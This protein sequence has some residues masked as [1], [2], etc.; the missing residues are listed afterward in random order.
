MVFKN[1]SFNKFW[2]FSCSFQLGIPIIVLLAV[3]AG[4]GTIIES[5]F[6]DALAAKKMV[7]DS[8]MMWVTM[9]LL[10]YNLVVVVV[11]RWPWKRMHYP[12]VVVHAGLI[13]I[14]FGGFITGKY[15]LDGQV[16]VP[17]SGQNN[18]ISVP[19]TDLVVYA[20][21][22]GD[23]YSKVVDREVDFFMH[24]PSGDMPYVL[25]LGEDKIQIIDFARYAIL[26]NKVKANQDLQSGASI[27]FQLMNAN[28]KQVQQIT[29]PK[30]NREVVFNLGPAKVILG[31]PKKGTEP[32]NEIYIVPVDADHA[33]YFIF[34]RDQ[35]KV[36]K[37]GQIK[38]GD[39]INTGWMGLEFRLLDYIQHAVEEYDITKVET[40][41][42]LTVQAVKIQHRDVIRWMALNDLVK[43]FGESKAYLFSYQN[44]RIDLGFQIHLDQFD[45]IRYE[46]TNKAKEYASKVSIVKNGEK[47]EARAKPEDLTLISMNEPMKHNG[48]TIYQA[49]FQEDEMTGK[50][51][52]S[53]FSVN[54]DPGRPIKYMGSLILSVGIIWLFYQRR[55]KATAV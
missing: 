5:Q 23:R 41:T 42:P 22:D 54:K 8:W 16:S 33:K 19:S 25:D 15:G 38:I 44:R 35:K 28:V 27:R 17:I 55:K 45:V 20:T 39:V 3:L 1:K 7:F 10:V 30:K 26:Q 49:S 52:A 50:P 29:Q 12:F 2:R 46:G 13:T 51:I 43:L 4:W 36:F 37:T 32:A 24:S 34:H 21:F 6:N 9:S 47:A 40:S 11:D 18:F 14:I 53:V 31:E 48:Y